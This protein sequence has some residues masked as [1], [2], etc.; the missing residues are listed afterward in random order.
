[1][2]HMGRD[3]DWIMDDTLTEEQ[4]RQRMAQ[5]GWEP[6]IS[7]SDNTAVAWKVTS[8]APQAVHSDVEQVRL[9]A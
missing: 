4:I 1:M 5:E 6:V 3:D 8:T 7:A 9:P 2:K